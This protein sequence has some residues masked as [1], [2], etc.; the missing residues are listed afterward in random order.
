MIYSK[1]KHYNSGN[2]LFL[3]FR[4]KRSHLIKK[5][6]SKIF[7]AKGSVNIIDLGGTESYWNIIETEFLLNNKV[8]ITL[9]NLINYKI[10]NK[11][12]FSQINKD[13]FKC[14]FKKYSFDLSFSNSVIEHIGDTK[15]QISFC[16]LHKNLAKFYYLQT[17][18]KYFFIEP[19]FM[20]PY[21][22]F[23]PRAVQLFILSNF[24]IGNFKKND[25]DYSINELNTIQLLSKKNL[26]KFFPK[27]YI[28]SEKIFFM[29]KSYI[30]T[31][32]KG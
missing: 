6:I 27:K 4:K 23:L 19:H 22:N 8:K 10:K 1:I 12:I 20:F 7:N 24:N 11:K 14:K 29:N 16:N 26:E 5:I 2:I 28:Y 17:P 25:L 15:K 21:F 13:F 31:N 18:N 3:N 32:L 30:V 9:I